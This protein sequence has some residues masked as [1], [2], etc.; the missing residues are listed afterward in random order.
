MKFQLTI[1]FIVLSVNGF[2]QSLTDSAYFFKQ[3]EKNIELDFKNATNLISS[4]VKKAGKAG[5]L[6]E[7]FQGH[8]RHVQEAE[9]ESIL[10]VAT[11]GI[12]T[13]GRFKTAGTF[14][15]SRIYQDSLAWTTKGTQI[16]AQPYYFGS[17]KAGTFERTIYDLSGILSYAIIKDRLA[18]ASGVDYNFVSSTRSVDPRPAVD[19]FRLVLKPE[20]IYS[21]GN[22]HL[23]IQANL[24]F[25]SETF[26]LSFKNR[27]YTE[28]LGSPDRINYMVYGYGLIEILQSNQST[29][30][31]QKYRG[32]EVN[33]GSKI[34]NTKIA[35][36]LAFNRWYD[37]NSYKTTNSITDNLIGT[38][39]LDELKGSIVANV[40]GV[41]HAQQFSI[42]TL[43]QTG[44]DKR[45]LYNSTNYTYNRQLVDGEYLIRLHHQRKKS[46]E[47][48]GT[49][50]YQ[51][52]AKKD[53]I[54][55][56]NVE[57]TKLEPGI[58]AG[59]Y[60]KGQHKNLFSVFIAGG[61]IIP[62]NNTITVP[63]LQETVF[64]RG[65]IYP[66]YTYDTS[67]AFRLSG[68]LNYIS[69]SLFKEF[70]TGF[71]I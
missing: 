43:S 16:D 13:L 36:N 42:Q 68:K 19:N 63:P 51:R 52:V 64:T 34:N 27:D 11:S 46:L 6:Y 61:Y 15:F 8:F 37:D 20:I 25:G 31:K 24:G 70:K 49:L 28:S 67:K 5:V 23:G 38:F 59:L 4:D 29:I 12:A 69:A 26:N 53:I 40:F 9:K 50:S 65:V 17:V 57:N 44:Q 41:K 66:N 48:G 62:F 58:S 33:Y 47:L 56:H 55:A 39:I 1:L 54:S 30:R 10:K 18:V 21:F 45:V 71:S 14:N 35:S 22:Q 3:S 2:C 32:F 60:V 7:L